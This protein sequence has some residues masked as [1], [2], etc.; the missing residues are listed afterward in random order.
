M[1]SSTL[2]SVL[3]YAVAISFLTVFIGML[4][5]CVIPTWRA[6]DQDKLR[7]K[8]IWNHV[9]IVL[10]ITWMVAVATAIPDAATAFSERV[11]DYNQQLAD[12][13]RKAAHDFASYVVDFRCNPAAEDVAGICGVVKDLLATEET[14]AKVWSDLAAAFTK[15]LKTAE[16]AGIDLGRWART[17][18]Q[19]LAIAAREVSDFAT[20]G[21]H[22]EEVKVG[23]PI[24]WQI[25]A[26]WPIL[27]AVGFALGLAKSRASYR[28]L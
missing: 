10:L 20:V 27:V 11:A 24:P 9:E 19:N 14:D 28:L 12:E 8:R 4:F 2:A 21:D 17:E 26:L 6:P 3:S 1:L 18:A 22:F 5:L 13:R 25:L 16:R 23:N 15:E 7:W